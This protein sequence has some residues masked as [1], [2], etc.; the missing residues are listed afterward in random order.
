MAAQK[1]RSRLCRLSIFLL[2]VPAVISTST[3]DNGK[4]LSV[5]GISYY[6]GGNSVSSL[7]TSVDFNSTQFDDIVPIT[8]IRTDETLLTKSSL[9][10]II[11]NY[12]ATDDVFQAGFLETVFL[13]YDGHGRGQIDPTAKQTFKDL[14]SSLLM[15]SPAYRPEAHITPAKI[16][17]DL[18]KGPYFYSPKTG[19]LY[20]AFRLYA[21][22]QLAF[23]EAALSD[24][25]GGFKP[26]PA[27]V[28]GAMTKSVAVPS[29]L[30]YTPS[31]QKP[32]A[33]LRVGIKDIFDLKGLRT[34]GG[35]RAYYDLYPPRNTTGPALQRLIDAGAVVIGK[36]GTVQFANGDN[37]TADWVDFHCPFNPRGDG[38]QAPG[39]SSS[40]PGAGM[41]SYD[42]LDIAIGSD[43]G[44]SMRSP[45][46]MQGLFANRPS[47][48]AVNLD[49][50][51]P[52]CH[53]LDTAGVF[54]RNAA[55]WSKVMHAWYENFTDYTE[56]PKKLFYQN[57]SF[58]AVNTTAGALIEEFVGKV[59]KFL[60]AKREFVNISSQWEETQPS[61]T[62]AISKFLNTT[63][64]SLV[65]VDQYRSLSLPFYEDYAA[66]HEGRRPFVNPGPLARWAWGQENG[67]DA[68]YDEAL[69][70]KTVFKDWWETK[71]FGKADDTTCSEG[72][73][74]Y[75]YSRGE[76]QYRNAYF[77]A[78][79]A[80][81]MGFS[82][83][84]IAVLAG[85]PDLV[86]PVG[87]IP[88]N[89]T[90]SL[91]TEYMPVTMSFVAAR[92][93]DLMLVNLIEDMEQAGILK[94]VSTGSRMYPE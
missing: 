67:G 19:E 49:N 26:L 91:K 48:G 74:I 68:A 51:I 11:A 64:A 32:L 82:D 37:P 22:H 6:S 73:Y 36:M 12:S 90:I 50:V 39:G 16:R 34:S 78:P 52:L 31:S 13:L 17:H 71:G 25:A 3:I 62:A 44:G 94:P 89:S 27:A 87:E 65:S 46:G 7:I 2:S 80:P 28:S 21:D 83:G 70:N 55:T 9:S 54:A 58:P 35:N 38:Y 4:L 23:T 43:T 93:C 61:G 79:S 20:Q 75:P 53:A 18:P 72:I 45:G 29:R 77:S 85:A 5:N 81:P 24:G 40:G 57:S 14:G 33:G 1:L 10:E 47:T 41:A 15:A 76:T 60:G 92:G 66:K 56:Y 69:K 42:W 8:V 63:Y 86:V 59:E 30:Y 88:Y 84:R